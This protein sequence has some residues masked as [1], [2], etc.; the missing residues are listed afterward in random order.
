MTHRIYMFD[1]PGAVAGI[2]TLRNYKAGRLCITKLPDEQ[3]PALDTGYLERDPLKFCWAVLF[4]FKLESCITHTVYGI[5][6]EHIVYKGCCA[7]RIHLCD[8]IEVL[9]RIIIGLIYKVGFATAI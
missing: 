1:H 6:S 3:G 2:I 4:R 7:F 8:R 5:R 9:L